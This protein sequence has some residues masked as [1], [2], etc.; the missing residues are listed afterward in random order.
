MPFIPVTTKLNYSSLQCYVIPQKSDVFLTCFI[1]CWLSVWCCV[2]VLSDI[3]HNQMN[4]MDILN[5]LSHLGGQSLHFFFCFFLFV[6]FY[7]FYVFFALRAFRVHREHRHW[8]LSGSLDWVG[9]K[10]TKETFKIILPSLNWFYCDLR[11]T[12]WIL[13]TR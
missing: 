3:C 10:S 8:K 1:Q 12:Q 13:E 5:S 7:L 11:T 2:S 4:Q 9:H 6:F